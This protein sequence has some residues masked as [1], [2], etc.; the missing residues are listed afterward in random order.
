MGLTL[1]GPSGWASVGGD[2]TSVG[3]LPWLPGVATTMIGAVPGW[4]G[5]GAGAIGSAR[6]GAAS[7]MMAPL[8]TAA[9][10]SALNSVL[11][12]LFVG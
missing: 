10:D 8:V 5:L 9:Q 7:A 12:V 6:A 1:A 3:W 2:M 11:Q 4:A